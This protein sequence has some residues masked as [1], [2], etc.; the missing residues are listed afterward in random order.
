MS[1]LRVFCL[2]YFRGGALYRM[3]VLSFLWGGLHEF[4]FFSLFNFG[5]LIIG[6]KSSFFASLLSLFTKDSS[7]S[8]SCTYSPDIYHLLAK[9][10]LLSTERRFS[11]TYVPAPCSNVLDLLT[12]DFFPVF[13]V[14]FLSS[15]SLESNLIFFLFFKVEAELPLLS[16][17]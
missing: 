12:R 9:S 11:S 6:L 4:L 14:F 7:I 8:S 15:V 17:L 1:E 10:A 5:K 16:F 13:K 2:F 3:I